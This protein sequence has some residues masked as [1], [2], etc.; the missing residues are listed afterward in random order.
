MLKPLHR[1]IAAAAMLVLASAGWADD[2]DARQ[3]YGA[4]N[5]DLQ[6]AVKRP[7]RAQRLS[8]WASAEAHFREAVRLKPDYADAWDKLGQALFNQEKVFD[9]VTALKHAV[10]IDPRMTEAWYDLGFSLENLDGEKQ[11]KADDKTRKKLGRSEVAD[12]IAAYRKALDV[13]PVN[14]VPSLAK[15]QFRLG[16]L[17]RDEAL[18]A[19]DAA[20][21][22]AVSPAAAVMPDQANLKEAMG[23]LEEAVRLVPDY[24][25]A[26]NELGRVYDLIGRYNAAIDQYSLA[27]RGQK[28]YAEAYSNRGVAWW[29]SGNWD[30]ALED[31]RKATEIN[32]D[33]A[34]GHYNLA[35]VV[36]ARVEE[37]RLKGSDGDRSVIHPEAQ[38]AVDEYLIAT[39]QDP[40]L[41]AAW[42]G[43]AK[44]YHGYF[45]FANAEKTYAKIVE[46]DKRQKRAKA[47]LKD[48]Q[49]EE[50]AFVSHIPKQ[51]RDDQKGK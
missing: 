44:A 27:I 10:L 35:E 17:L 28:D 29:K 3:A 9:A 18:K 46:M 51:Y 50:K 49:K 14:D 37:L 25:E 45:D 38:K 13:S 2:T 36:F 21:A 34:G 33:F 43:L 41:M 20:Q 7:S 5:T 30:K 16:V 26:R 32:P 6:T 1:A 40:D 47:L 22:A 24:P 15:A 48:V 23:H 4:G 42:Y 19:A 11:I 39:R 31:C 12:A 8:D